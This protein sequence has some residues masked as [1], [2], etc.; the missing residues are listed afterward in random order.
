MNYEAEKRIAKD[1]EQNPELY[2]ALA[3]D[4]GDTMDTTNSHEDIDDVLF[5]QFPAAWRPG[6]VKEAVDKI[7]S[8]VDELGVEVVAV[9]EEVDLLSRDE[10][11]EIADEL[12][13]VAQSK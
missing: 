1:V 10:V 12:K 8:A 11:E 2:Q 3:D 7:G 5:I 6:E 9:T 13:E 4:K